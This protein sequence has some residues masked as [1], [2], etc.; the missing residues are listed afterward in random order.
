MKKGVAINE[1][2]EVVRSQVLQE[3]GTAFLRGLSL[4]SDREPSKK[5]RQNSDM[6]SFLFF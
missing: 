1:G 6:I 5:F 3:F 4:P 2:E